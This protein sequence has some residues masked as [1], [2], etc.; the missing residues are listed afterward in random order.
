MSNY[1]KEYTLNEMLAAAVARELR[2]GEVG[3]IGRGTGDRAFTLAVGLPVVATRLAQ[4]SHAPNCH[5]QMGGMITPRL[6]QVPEVLNESSMTD[7]RCSA[8][9]PTYE[10]MEYVAK[11]GVDVAFVSGAQ[12]DKF[13]NLNITAIGD[14]RKTKVR[15]IGCLALPEHLAFARRPFIV[16]DLNKRVFIEKV[17]FIT[18][19]GYLTGGNSRIHAG[20]K[21]QGPYMVFTDKAL[22]DFDE[23]TKVMRLKSLHPGVSVEDVK[24]NMGFAPVIPEDVPTT[25]PPT[26]EQVRLI[27]EVIDPNKTLLR[28]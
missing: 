8:Q 20:L 16:A 10:I 4:M 7:W 28:A 6:D 12:I 21:P 1:A 24:A 25:E 22:F 26:E 19:A 23:D 27:R 13:G 2:D 9:L 15:L 14:Y 18:G 3:F 11:G 5:L 17:D